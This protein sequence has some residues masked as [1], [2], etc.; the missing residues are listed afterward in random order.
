MDGKETKVTFQNFPDA[1]KS[2]LIGLLLSA[3]SLVRSLIAI[4]VIYL[5]MLIGKCFLPGKWT[6]ICSLHF[7][8][9]FLQLLVNWNI[10]HSVVWETKSHSSQDTSIEASGSSTAVN[11]LMK[12]VLCDI[13]I[14]I[15]IRYRCDISN[16]LR[17]RYDFDNIILSKSY[18]KSFLIYQCINLLILELQCISCI[19]LQAL[20]SMHALSVILNVLLEW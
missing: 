6:K 4:A 18:C 17:Y 10:K 2:V 19:L 1:T 7:E 11:K 15:S 8:Q 5:F 20:I 13:R 16:I 3:M 14:F 12:L 9:R